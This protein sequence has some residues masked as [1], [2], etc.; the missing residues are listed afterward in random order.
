MSAIIVHPP[1][2]KDIRGLSVAELTSAMVLRGEKPF[3]AK[4]VYEWLWKKGARN[5]DEMTNL[6]LKLRDSLK[7][8]FSFPVMTEDKVQRSADGTIKNRFRLHDGHLIESVLIPVEDGDR[9]TV[10][11]S[12]QVGC[13][14]SC[15]FCATGRMKRL[16]NLTAAEI[17]DQVYLVNEQCLET[18]G[19][20]L[21]NIVYMGMGEPLLAFREVV[22]SIDRITSHTGLHMAPRRLTVSTAGIAKMITKLADE[23]TKVNLAISLHA[24]DDTKRNEIMPINESNNLEVLVAS[25]KYFYEKTKKRIGIE[26]ITFQ[27]FNDTPAD[28]ENLYRICREF[29]SMVNIIE[30]NP[31]DNAPFRKSTAHRIDDFATYLRDRGVMVTV[32]RSRG[33]DIDAACGQLANKE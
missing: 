20:P 31:I 9:F 2:L 13:S 11:V 17:Y 22:Q 18:Y 28:A 1:Q 14:L 33:K 32:R 19:K 12:S 21:T 15:T 29:P 5:F 8:Q 7:E 10:C 24:A 26:Y 4:Q 6:S 25:L 16:R 27:D 30:Y 3:R 23:D